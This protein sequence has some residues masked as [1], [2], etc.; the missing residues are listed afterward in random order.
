MDEEMWITFQCQ[1]INGLARIMNSRDRAD[2]RLIDEA[3]QVLSH[4]QSTSTPTLAF[5]HF[6]ARVTWEY[7]AASRCLRESREWSTHLIECS[8]ARNSLLTLT[9]VESTYTETLWKAGKRADR[10]TGVYSFS[11]APKSRRDKLKGW[12]RDDLKDE[13]EA[14]FQTRQAEIAKH[15]EIIR[16]QEAIHSQQMRAEEAQRK[17]DARHRD[18]LMMEKEIYSAQKFWPETGDR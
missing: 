2:D 9:A 8:K 1:S 11:Q 14:L 18:P 12:I 16:R 4:F 5:H 6:A 7:L 15:A 10:W 17:L 3:E 13:A